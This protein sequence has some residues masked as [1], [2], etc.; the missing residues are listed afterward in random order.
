M[1]KI[2]KSKNVRFVLEV[3][4][5]KSVIDSTLPRESVKKMIHDEVDAMFAGDFTVVGED[6]FCDKTGFHLKGRYL[7]GL[8]PQGF[9]KTYSEVNKSEK[10]KN[11]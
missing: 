8:T 10:Q 11:H 3:D 2:E 1:K 5:Y 6:R 4:G 7:I 9:T